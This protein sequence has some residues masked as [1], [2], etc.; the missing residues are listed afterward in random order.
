MNSRSDTQSNKKSFFYLQ[1][2]AT[3]ESRTVTALIYVRGLQGLQAGWNDIVFLNLV[4][5]TKPWNIVDKDR[6]IILLNQIP[7][8]TK[9]RMQN[10]CKKRNKQ[11]S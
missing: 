7:S 10:I 6:C 1:V 2:A 8:Y 5:A 3:E 11:I 4:F 9:P